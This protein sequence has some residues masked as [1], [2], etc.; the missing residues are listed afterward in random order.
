MLEQMLEKLTRK[1]GE[2][3]K[4]AHKKAINLTS[5]N[6]L[7]KVEEVAIT[8][9]SSNFVGKVKGMAGRLSDFWQSVK[10]LPSILWSLVKNKKYKIEPKRKSIGEEGEQAVKGYDATLGEQFDEM[11]GT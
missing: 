10:G 11:Q 2:K 5:S 9:T 4:N 3:V 6:F 1:Q 8:L 7:G